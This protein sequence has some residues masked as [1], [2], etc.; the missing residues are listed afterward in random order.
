DFFLGNYGRQTEAKNN[1]WVDATN[2]Q[3]NQLF[4][5]VDGRRFE[6]V[7]EKAGL[8]DDHWTYS[9]AAAD[10][11]RDGDADLYVVNDFGPNFLM[12]NDGNGRFTDVTDDVTRDPGNGMSAS[13]CDL[14][15]D[16]RLDLYLSN[17]WNEA[18]DRIVARLTLQ[19]P[20]VDLVRKFARGNSILF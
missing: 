5:N 12:R 20:E 11:D 10:Y 19:G 7:T 6:D 16:G 2:G 1:S 14:D 4:R 15:N 13:W 9:S 18:A 8:S 17:M 3:S